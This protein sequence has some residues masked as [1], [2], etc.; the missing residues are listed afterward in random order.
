MRFY[1]SLL[2]LALFACEE[3]PQKPPET[4]PPELTRANGT[5]LPPTRVAPCY[6][7]QAESDDAGVTPPKPERIK[8][9]SLT[10]A[11]VQSC[12]D[13]SKAAG[14]T[15][16][17]ATTFL[18]TVGIDDRVSSI[19]V[20]DSC[21]ISAHSI[22]CFAQAFQHA[23]VD[24]Q[25]ALKKGSL[26]ITF[27]EGRHEL[28]SASSSVGFTTVH[29]FTVRATDVFGRS[30]G[31]LDACAKAAAAK[32]KFEPTWAQFSLLLEGDG[33]VREVQVDPF[34]GNQ[35]LL[36]CAAEV[37]QKLELPPPPKGAET[38]REHLSFEPPP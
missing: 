6:T 38:V 15:P 28:R 24:P 11:D 10:A 34:A 23:R 31:A 7:T 13:E 37:L 2:F 35:P 25:A 18:V 27:G 16:N 3:T 12:V 26:Q 5:D 17:G 36:A 1:R 4:P 22:L 8:G 14:E 21:G 19:E 9:V 33:K 30:R 29:D 32:G 20:M